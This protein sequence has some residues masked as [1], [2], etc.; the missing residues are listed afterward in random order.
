MEARLK[1]MGGCKTRGPDLGHCT[2][3]HAETEQVQKKRVEGKRVAQKCERGHP[4]SQKDG[5]VFW[6]F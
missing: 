4:L 1:P 3:A 2:G 6:N 5:E